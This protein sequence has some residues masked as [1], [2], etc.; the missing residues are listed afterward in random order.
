[1]SSATAAW[2]PPASARAMLAPTVVNASPGASSRDH[3]WSVSV[4]PSRTSARAS[5][6]LKRSATS[7]RH[8]PGCSTSQARARPDPPRAAACSRTAVGRWRA[9]DQVLVLTATTAP[10][11]SGSWRSVVESARA[12]S[13]NSGRADQRNSAS[14]WLVPRCS[15]S[16][17]GSCPVPRTVPVDSDDTS[18]STTASGPV[19]SSVVVTRTA[20]AP[21]AAASPVKVVVAV[22][23]LAGSCWTTSR[24]R[25]PSA[26]RSRWR[27]CRRRRP[28][29]VSVD[30]GPVRARP[31]PVRS[32]S[33]SGARAPVGSGGPPAP[34][35]MRATGSEGSVRSAR[36]R[37]P[38]L[39]RRRVSAGCCAGGFVASTAAP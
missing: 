32:T 11:P 21:V 37:P 22:R 6:P 26:S 5:S 12:S 8:P 1:M 31:S 14:C 39:Q 16:W 20:A 24:L 10:R 3:W 36:C 15:S 7:Q 23:P 4:G 33:T 35:P 18:S 2:C 19:F 30:R 25:S 13:S 28:T 9:V 34:R 27:R 17:W 29:P 38:A